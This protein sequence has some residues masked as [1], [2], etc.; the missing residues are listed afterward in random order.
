[1]AAE[2]SEE[3]V[4]QFEALFA[5]PTIP[6]IL[7]YPW[8][9][10]EGFVEYVF[11]CAGYAVRNVSGNKWPNGPGVDLELYVDKVGG[12]LAAMVEVRRYTPPDKID[13]D[14][15]H[16]FAN[17]LNIAKVPGYLVTT[18][19]FVE[20]AKVAEAKSSRMTLVNGAHL[21]RY[22][23]YIRGS[24]IKESGPRRPTTPA[25]TPPDFLFEADGIARR[26]V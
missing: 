20:G 21:R 23:A 10:F 12:K 16:A 4:G 26:E 8:Q 24:R 2:F 6:A 9:H 7:A 13:S 17:K 1:M 14:Q 25:P 5:N 19:D 22:I 18:S 11:A 15:A 3:T